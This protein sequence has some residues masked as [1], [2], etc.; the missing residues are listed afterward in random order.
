MI[1]HLLS[2]ALHMLCRWWHIYHDFSKAQE[3]FEFVDDKNSYIFVLSKKNKF[4]DLSNYI[5][6]YVKA[7]VRLA[8]LDLGLLR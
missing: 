4:L 5:V 2:H 8:F 3:L 1:R 7:N 6:L